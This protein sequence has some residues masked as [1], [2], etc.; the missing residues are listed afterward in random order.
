MPTVEAKFVLQTF[1]RATREADGRHPSRDPMIL[2][3]RRYEGLTIRVTG[4]AAAWYLRYKK[5]FHRL[6]PVG[7]DENTTVDER[8]KGLLYAVEVAKELA[9]NLREIIDRGFDPK[10]YI[11]AWAEHGDCEKAAAAAGSVAAKE[12]GAWNWGQLVERFLRDHIAQDKHLDHAVKPASGRTFK[13]VDDILRDPALD[14]LKT[15]LVRDLSRADFEPVRDR[16][17]E[18]G[19]KTRQ[20][21]LITYTKSALSWAKENFAESGLDDVASW[22]K[23]MRHRAF[24]SKAAVAKSRGEKLPRILTAADVAMLLFIAEKNRSLPDN[25][26]PGRTGEITLSYLWWVCLTAQRT[27]AAAAVRTSMIRD[28]VREDGWHEVSWLPSDVKSRRLHVLPISTEIYRRTIGR[29]LAAPN[30]RE[31]TVWAF[32]TNRIIKVEKGDPDR[33]VGDWILNNLLARLRGERTD[34]PDLLAEAGVPPSSP[35]TG[36]REALADLPR[37]HGPCRAGTASAIL[38]H[39]AMPSETADSRRPSLGAGTT[40]ASHIRHAA[41]ASPGLVRR[42]PRPSSGEYE[43]TRREGEHTERYGLMSGW[44]AG[45]SQSPCAKMETEAPQDR[46]A[47]RPST[48]PGPRPKPRSPSD[49]VDLRLHPE[50]PRSTPPP[51]TG[52]A[53]TTAWTT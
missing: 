38:D 41:E 22:W 49:A 30:R 33:P 27:H 50:A 2:V 23:D 26:N 7:Y 24:A 47:L 46:M 16:W 31:D 10:A 34:G 52:T 20:K 4:K 45:R 36:L 43:E 17:F 14:H 53:T 51:T 21:K 6:A 8:E 19:R 11:A 5:V 37:G 39:A 42:G 13:E 40:T 18:A 32:P 12:A 3:D 35:C 25:D 29:A 44:G 1:K 9:E 15:K 48:F 28:R